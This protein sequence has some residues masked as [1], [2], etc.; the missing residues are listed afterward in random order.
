MHWPELPPVHGMLST[1]GSPPGEVWPA[2]GEF[3]TRSGVHSPVK[4]SSDSPPGHA[5]IVG[6]ELVGTATTATTGAAAMATAN[7]P[8]RISRRAGSFKVAIVT[9]SVVVVRLR[10]SHCR[11]PPSHL[12][13]QRLRRPARYRCVIVKKVVRVSHFCELAVKWLWH[14]FTGA[15]WG[16]VMCNASVVFQANEVV[17]CGKP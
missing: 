14:R 8:A 10:E 16:T 5:A 11:C 4:V 12:L 6:A 3:G 15:C 7:P 9:L 13:L 17:R 2:S 1:P